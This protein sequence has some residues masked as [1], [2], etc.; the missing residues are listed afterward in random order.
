MPDFWSPVYRDLPEGRMKHSKRH[1]DRNVT[2]ARRPEDSTHLKPDDREEQLLHDSAA[3]YW[4]S[5]WP[6]TVQQGKHPI[7]VITALLV[8]NVAGAGLGAFLLIGYFCLIEL[9]GGYYTPIGVDSNEYRWLCIFTTAGMLLCGIPVITPLG[10]VRPS[11]IPVWLPICSYI[12]VA[13]ELT[14]LGVT[15]IL[16]VTAC[17]SGLTEGMT[18]VLQ[19]LILALVYSICYCLAITVAMLAGR[20]KRSRLLKHE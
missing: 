10:M 9:M 14:V 8:I 1:H 2:P 11:K 7:G 17:W 6:Q 15:L 3:L 4:K 5:E 18:L 13:L 16:I 20:I 19:G 12:A